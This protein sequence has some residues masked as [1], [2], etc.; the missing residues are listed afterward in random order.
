MHGRRLA[1]DRDMAAAG[2]ELDP[3]GR[4]DAAQ[5]LVAGA[6]EELEPL[7]GEIQFG[8]A[9]DGRRHRVEPDL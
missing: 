7:L 8:H 1:L 9:A 3:E 6:E 4:L 5:V 2:R